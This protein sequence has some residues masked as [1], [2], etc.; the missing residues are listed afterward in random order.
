MKHPSL[1]RRLTALV[2]AATTT[3]VLVGCGASTSTST[4]TGTGTAS[5]A[6]V[7]AGTSAADVLADDQQ[8]HAD[9]DT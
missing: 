5:T 8:P 6:S 7:V 3:V 9:A 2:A 1:T 4:S